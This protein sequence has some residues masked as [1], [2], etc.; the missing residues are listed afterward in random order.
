MIGRVPS[1]YKILER[2]GRGGMGGVFL[3]EDTSLDRK[4]KAAAALNHPN[5]VTIHSVE[6][7]EGVQF[8]TMELV[9]G[10]RLSE[11]L[12]KGGMAQSKFLE[13]AVPITDR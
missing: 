1:H 8:I 9:Q 13:L 2:I 7:A 5:I 3:A 10:K 6:Q 11:I 12:S 4:A